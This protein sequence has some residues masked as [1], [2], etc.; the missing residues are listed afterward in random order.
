[1]GLI[2]V[3]PFYFILNAYSIASPSVVSLFE[4]SLIIWAILI[5]Y[6]LFDNIPSIRTLIGAI[7]IISAGIYIYLR[8]RIKEQL[9]VSDNPIR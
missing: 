2:S 5:G 4:Y 9:I 1:M 8:E 7:I 3:L 6:I